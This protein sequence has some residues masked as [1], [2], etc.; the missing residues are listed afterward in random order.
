MVTSATSTSTNWYE[1][2]FYHAFKKLSDYSGFF[3][4]LEIISNPE[5]VIP[6]PARSQGTRERF[7]ERQ[8]STNPMPELTAAAAPP[9]QGDFFSRRHCGRRRSL[10]Q[11]TVSTFADHDILLATR[12]WMRRRRHSAISHSSPATATLLTGTAPPLPPRDVTSAPGRED[13]D[14][15]LAMRM[16]M[17]QRRPSPPSQPKLMST[18]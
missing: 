1:N 13:H 9:Q 10:P 4:S 8:G 6:N 18:F 7:K 12:M 11:D 14:Q 5:A 3:L 17:R 16:W 2:S 15:L